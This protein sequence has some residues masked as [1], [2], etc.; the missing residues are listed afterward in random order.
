MIL[1]KQHITKA[2]S[3]ERE[4]MLKANK[5]VPKTMKMVTAQVLKFDTLCM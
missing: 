1:G 5:V 3:L 2:V 4:A